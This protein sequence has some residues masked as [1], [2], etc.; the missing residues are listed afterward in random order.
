MRLSYCRRTLYA[1]FGV[2][3]IVVPPPLL[4]TLVGAPTDLLGF[5][6][7]TSWRHLDTGEIRIL[8]LQAGAVAL[9]LLWLRLAGAL[10]AEGLHRSRPERGEA[11]TRRGPFRRLAA[12][13]V[14][15]AM[16]LGP[17]APAMP[18][19]AQQPATVASVS[20]GSTGIRLGWAEAGFLSAA[21][22]AAVALRRQARLRRLRMP[23]HVV[24]AAANETGL[25]RRIQRSATA[26][27]VASLDALWAYVW[28][29]AHSLQRCPTVATLSAAG[30][31]VFWFDDAA[32]EPPTGIAL[33]NSQQWSGRLGSQLPVAAVQHPVPTEVPPPL[34]HV[35]HSAL[36]SVHL[37]LD[38][39]STLVI[40]GPDV[41]SGHIHRALGLAVQLAGA[42]QRPSSNQ[43]LPQPRSSSAGSPSRLALDTDG[44]VLM[45]VGLRVQPIGLDEHDFLE[46]RALLAR[47]DDAAAIV[48]VSPIV[49]EGVIVRQFW[50]AP[51]GDPVALEPPTGDVSGE[52][53]QTAEAAM[54]SPS[55]HW[56]FIVR[57]LGPVDVLDADGRPVTFE[58]SKSLELI[59]WLALHRRA[60]SREA[61]RA[62]LWDTEVRD[63]SFANVVSEARRAL[64][65]RVRPPHG[66]E[67]LTRPHGERLGLHE[68]VVCD[69]DLFEMH[70]KRAATASS[71]EDASQEL[72][73]ALGLVRG[74][75][76]VGSGY[77][78]ADSEAITSNA[79]LLVV[80]VA[81]DLA[82]RELAGQNTDGVFWATG[83][84]LGVLPGHEELVA[85]RL[86][87]HALVGDTVGIR[88]EW[89]TYLRSLARDPWQSEPSTW[90]EELAHE[91]LGDRAVA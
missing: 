2:A 57:V 75:P 58:K 49:S 86:R 55:T 66:S 39:A 23:A 22:V 34:V 6:P 61:S 11:T 43:P 41:E 63:S 84:G 78:W 37:T 36:G 73:T 60:G 32:P 8:L 5:R 14:G 81:A 79:T 83:I 50:A 69:L 16:S 47:A 17:V 67:W 7:R 56:S 4:L 35:G 10:L 90:L 9:W 38:V 80:G 28:S 48:E 54:S 26:T 21:V 51:S 24:P 40:D 1:M 27:P 42:R 29:A 70:R 74:A 19:V 31:V 30:E 13:V 18:V 52:H 91:L 64:A 62:A 88:H 33:G 53:G 59:A 65:R 25:L 20:F 82:E 44:W 3:L 89:Q 77:G 15:G 45:P 76:F 46:V 68:A 71:P 72:R 85:L 87:A 12:V